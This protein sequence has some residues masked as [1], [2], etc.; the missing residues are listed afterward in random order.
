RLF[1]TWSMRGIKV[2]EIRTDIFDRCLVNGIFQPPQT[3]HFI[4][5]HLC[6]TLPTD[7]WRA[8]K[9]PRDNQSKSPVG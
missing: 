6:L 4:L 9:P 1:E 2:S 3:P 8:I 7:T 5:E